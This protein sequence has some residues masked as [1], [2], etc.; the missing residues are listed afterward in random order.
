MGA[1]TRTVGPEG[2]YDTIQAAIDAA[3]DGDTIEVAAGTYEEAITIDKPLTLLGAQAGIDARDRTGEESIVDPNDPDGGADKSWVIRVRA[4]DVTIDGFTI[5]NPT[6][7]YGS[8][9]LVDATGTNGSLDNIVVR[10]NIL[11]SPGVRTSGSTN[12]GKFGINVENTTNC[13]IERNYI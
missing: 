3:E 12:W 11:Q 5:Q 4:S 1:D 6:L 7:M 13:L 8:A 2:D 9:G 10:N